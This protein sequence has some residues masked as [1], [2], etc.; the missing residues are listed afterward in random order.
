MTLLLSGSALNPAAN[1]TT[2]AAATDEVKVQAGGGNA[3][4]L[5]TIFAPQEVEVKIGQS[6]TWYNPTQGVAEPHTV[7]FVFDN[8]KLTDVVSPLAVSNTTRFMP[9][10]P[11][12]NNEPLLITDKTGT[13]MNTIFALN[14]RSHQPV[15]IDS[16]DNVKFMNPNAN[17]SLAGSEKYA[18]SG[19]L[20]PEGHE[21]EFPNSGTTFT[22]TF[23]KS[24]T[25]DYMCVF[26]PW[27]KGSVI[28][29]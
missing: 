29:K 11:G 24:G 1:T 23:K 8:N 12:S 19:W 15:S 17:Y 2:A 4:G 18:N 3:T 5:W 25:Y 7:T 14:A 9:L 10:P 27:M 13:G 26:H 16:Q 28:V 22:V 6:V 20:V 21:Q